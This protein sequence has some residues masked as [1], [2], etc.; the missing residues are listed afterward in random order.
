MTDPRA[1]TPR[2]H[3]E[4]IVRPKAAEDVLRVSRHRPSDSLAEYVDYYWLVRWD[5]VTTH[6]Q[7]VVPQPCVHVAAE[8]GRLLVHGLSRA[9]FFRTLTGP[10]H[11]LGVAFHAA[12][13]RPLLG[14]SVA[15]ITG[16]VT[17]AAELLG[18][19]DR[20]VA[21]HI[22]ATDDAPAM[23]SAMDDYLGS[24][25][26][27]PDPTA[28]QV[29]ALVSAARHDITITRAEGLARHAGVSLRT[30][31]R[32]FTEYVGIGP[33]WVVQRFRLL[34]AAAA[35][36]GGSTVDWAALAADLGFSDQ[37]HLTRLFT[38]VVGTPPATY[39]RDPG[40]R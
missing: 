32:L 33:K 19:D 26:P 38:Q 2:G 25:G 8:D 39:L 4:A 7:Q 6:R 3:P 35:A 27:W 1:T 34:D 31:Q 40:T 10:G 18:P 13:F 17:P 15:R 14:S 12:G 24:V 22:L 30:L 21:G 28:R 20:D 23:I 5:P 29:T 37:A 11:V 16:T 36:H 9:P